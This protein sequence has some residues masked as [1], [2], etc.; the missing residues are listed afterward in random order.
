MTLGKNIKINSLCNLLKWFNFKCVP[1]LKKVFFFFRRRGGGGRWWIRPDPSGWWY[2]MDA[3]RIWVCLC[4]LPPPTSAIKSPRRLY[5]MA[6]IWRRFSSL[7]CYSSCFS[8]FILFDC[9]CVSY[10]FRQQSVCY[11]PLF[12]HCSKNIFP[13]IIINNPQIWNKTFFFFFFKY[14]YY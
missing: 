10:E 7:L 8:V 13:F 11:V 1:H 9:L 14:Y 12:R 2:I 6:P 5:M 4:L 3:N